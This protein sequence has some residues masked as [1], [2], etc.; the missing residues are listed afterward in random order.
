[1]RGA[2]DH[3]RHAKKSRCKGSGLSSKC[4]REVANHS[5]CKRSFVASPC[6]AGM[7]VEPIVSSL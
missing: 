3:V 4:K 6:D 7:G 5:I 2:P 1:M